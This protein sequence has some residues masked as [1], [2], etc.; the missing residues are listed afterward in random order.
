M[1]RQI[2]LLFLLT[3]CSPWTALAEQP[4]A[5]TA[6]LAE[7]QV[8]GQVFFEEGSAVLNGAGQREIARLLPQLRA[9]D[10]TVLVLRIEGFAGAGDHAA[11]S[12]P[13]GMRRAQ[14]VA[15]RLAVLLGTDFYLTGCDAE[16]C[17]PS[18]GQQRA[19]ADIVLYHNSLHLGTTPVEQVVRQWPEREG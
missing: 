14:A 10:S 11:G 15:E 6:F 2:L 8:V 13:M 9:I 18:Q 7:R 4:E 16:Q 1:R 3:F 17:S 5:V 12:L 19:R